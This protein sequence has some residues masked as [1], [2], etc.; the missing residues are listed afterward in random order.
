MFNKPMIAI[1]IGSSSVK[2]IELARSAQRKVGAIGLEIFGAEAIA[3]GEIRDPDVVADVVAELVHR[4][5]VNTKN[6]RA[7]ISLGGS[8]I[9]IKRAVIQPNNDTDF[10]EQVFFEAQQLFH[11]DMDDMYFRY[12]EVRSRFCPPGK[13][14]VI[15]VG[16]KRELV[17]MHLSILRSMDLKTGVVD[18]DVLC[19]ANMFEHN[20]PV[21]DGLVVLT[22]VGASSTQ[23]ALLYRGEFLYTRDVYVGGNAYNHKIMESLGVD[24]NSAESLKLAASAGDPSI[25]PQVVQAISQVND[26]LVAEIKTTFEFF[27]QNEDRPADLPRPNMV[28]LAG[29]GARSIGLDA[30]VAAGFGVPVQIINPFQRVKISGSSQTTKHLLA[31]GPLYSTAMGLALRDSDDTGIE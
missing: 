17:E 18:C 11:H 12:Q 22:N 2:I 21:F 31:Q 19:L 4:L 27:L 23:V 9:L 30:A 13:K 15:L 16:A 24:F 14:A 20:Y 28:F 26:S 29:G 7:A 25:H 8:G 3:D 5:K 6:R 1:D 10:S